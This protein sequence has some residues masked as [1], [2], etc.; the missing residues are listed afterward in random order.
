MQPDLTIA[1]FEAGNIDP[2]QFNHQGHLYVAWLYIRQYG[3]LDAITRFDAA[4]RRLT[5]QCGIPGKYHATM[6][7]FFL[8]LISERFE[9]RDGWHTFCR[10]NADLVT[11]SKKTLGRYYSEDLMFSKIARERFVLPDNLKI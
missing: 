5:Q 11:E 3:T 9:E 6:T 8:L 10:K 1:D 7:W 2:E 4:L